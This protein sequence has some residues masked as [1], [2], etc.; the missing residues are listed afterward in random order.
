MSSKRLSIVIPTYNRKTRLARVLSALEVQDVDLGE[1][2]VVI[3]DDGSTDG[4]ADWLAAQ[5]LRFDCR[6]IRLTN[7]GP[8]RAR[9]AGV[10]AAAGELVLFLDDDVEPTPSLVSEH[11]R[12]HARESDLVVLGPLAS[13]PSYAQPWVAWEQ[14][15]I[16]AQYDAMQRGELVPTFRQFW[17]G[18]ASL[19]RRH[20][21]AAGGF[22]PSFLRGEDVEL[23]QRL[24]RLGLKF[25]FNARARGLHHAE[26]SL[27][28]WENAH[29]SYGRLE[30]EIFERIG[31]GAAVEVLADNWGRVHPG[32]RW[33]VATCI[34]RPRRHAA[35]RT[36]LHNHLE[37]AR[38]VRL[39]LLTEKSCSLLAN[40][41]Y[42]QASSDALGPARATQIFRR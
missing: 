28:S 39:P 7:G 27:D 22:N 32:I 12:T 18:N 11:L 9:N 26:R 13:L 38:R 1:M 15:K 10:D 31:E 17:T 24:A 42:W 16:E 8:A 33:V 19:A 37:L 25:R 20:L 2:E 34:G 40:L 6:V 23:G 36:L 30:V 5:R 21:I 14:A 4:S 35:V 41:M 3:V 29:A